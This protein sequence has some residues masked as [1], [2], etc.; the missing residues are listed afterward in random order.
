MKIVGTIIVACTALATYTTNLNAYNYIF[1]KGK[2]AGGEMMCSD[3]SRA[4]NPS[5]T[6]AMTQWVFGFITGY[7]AATRPG[8][9]EGYF[10]GQPL[11]NNIVESCKKNPK[12]DLVSVAKYIATY[13]QKEINGEVS[14]PVIW[15][16]GSGV[17][18]EPDPDRW[19]IVK[20]VNRN[21]CTVSASKPT[22]DDLV[23][24]TSFKAYVMGG[25]AMKDMVVAECGCERGCSFELPP[26]G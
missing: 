22:N 13:I 26:K 8:P 15:N 9:S 18:P 6:A 24:L 11:A 20:D 16:R 12:A 23:I 25:K 4:T 3:W 1:L 21:T 7:D 2:G 17:A 5:E 19:L 10:N 14:P